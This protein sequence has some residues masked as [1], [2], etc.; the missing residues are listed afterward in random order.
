MKI[1]NDVLTSRDNVTFDAI[2]VLAVATVAVALVLEIYAVVMQKPFDVQAFGIGMSAVFVAV[3][4]A[5]KLGA[6]PIGTT[7]TQTTTVTKTETP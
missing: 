4:A 1:L 6:E 7:A 3:G 2:R 5:L